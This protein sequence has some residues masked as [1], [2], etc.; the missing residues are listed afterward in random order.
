MVKDG[1]H[2]GHSWVAEMSKW[3]PLVFFLTRVGVSIADRGRGIHKDK[4]PNLKFKVMDHKKWSGTD[5]LYFFYYFYQLCRGFCGEP[6]WHV[7]MNFVGFRSTLGT[8]W[9]IQISLGTHRWHPPIYL[10]K[11]STIEH[12]F[13]RMLTSLR[14]SPK[15]LSAKINIVGFIYIYPPLQLWKVSI[16]HKSWENTLFVCRNI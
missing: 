7:S 4:R 16:A 12:P 2:I 11:V 14:N 6:G 3:P 5:I 8:Q 13:L 15:Y 9:H 1:C 10:C